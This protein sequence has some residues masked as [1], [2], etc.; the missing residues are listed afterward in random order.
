MVVH[1]LGVSPWQ[2]D[3]D[4]PLALERLGDGPIVLQLFLRG[5]PFRGERDRQ[6]PWCAAVQQLQRL[7]RLAGLIVYGSPYLWEALRSMLHPSIPAGFSPGQ[8][9]EAQRQLLS[10]LLQP[11]A[12][13]PASRDFTD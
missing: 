4:A 12:K 9:P 3:P 11:Q 6:E 13:R 1:G 10:R 8:M 2:D 5:N 7:D